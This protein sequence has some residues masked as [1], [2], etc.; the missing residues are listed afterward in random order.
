MDKIYTVI[1]NHNGELHVSNY[2]TL[3]KAYDELMFTLKLF[4]LMPEVCREY[5]GENVE[6]PVVK[7]IR[8]EKINDDVLCGCDPIAMVCHKRRDSKR[9]FYLV[10]T[11]IEN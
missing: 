7:C 2:T 6:I 11:E 4:R 3:D 1:E 9:L 5:R 8:K 10:K